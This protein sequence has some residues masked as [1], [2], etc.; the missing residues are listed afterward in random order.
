[1][2]KLNGAGEQ[3]SQVNSHTT[4]IKKSSL[5]VTKSCSSEDFHENGSKHTKYW[6]AL[7]NF[8]PIRMKKRKAPAA[9]D[10]ANLFSFMT[11]NWLTSTIL[12][13]R[14]SLKLEDLPI[15]SEYDSAKS[16]AE[17]LTRLYEKDKK[18]NKTPSIKRILLRYIRT[19]TI[20]SSIAI[21]IS[22][23]A[24][25]ISP[26]FL[27]SRLIRFAALPNPSLGYGIGLVCALGLTEFSRT[28][29][30][31]LYW[32][33]TYR[34]TIRVRA[35]VLALIFQKIA[36]LRSLKDKS[37][38]ELVNLLAND[39][40]R[41][42]EAFQLCGLLVGTPFM[43]LLATIFCCIFIGWTALVGVFAFAAF[44]P[45][46]VFLAEKMAKYR[47]KTIEI[48]DKRV[49]MMNEILTCVKLIKMYAWEKSFAKVI[50]KIRDQERAILA[51]AGFVQSFQVTIVPIVPVMSTVFLFLVHTLVGYPL[52]ATIALTILAIF[53][54]LRFILGVMPHAVKAVSEV[55]V[56][57]NRIDSLLLM[58]EMEK[59]YITTT[60]DV[61]AVEIKHLTSAWDVI[62]KKER[63]KRSKKKV[64]SE[65]ENQKQ[66]EKT[67]PVLFDVSITVPKKRL[68][69]ICGSVG[70]GKSS[71]IS[72][73]LGHLRIQ[74]GSVG[75]NGTLAYVPQQAWIFHASVRDNILFGMPWDKEKYEQVVAACSLS[76]D[77][78]IL[79]DK[80]FTEVGERGLNLSGGQKQRIS[81]AR[82]VYSERE[83]VL[84]DDP[85][86]AVDAHVGKH[87]FF[88][89]IKKILANRTVIFVTHQLQY[90]KDCDEVVMLKEGRITEYG[91]HNELMTNKS[92]YSELINNFYLEQEKEKKSQ[93]E[94]VE[95]ELVKKMMRDKT[96][97]GVSRNALDTLGLASIG[98]RH[99]KPQ[100][101]PTVFRRFPSVRSVSSLTAEG[102]IA[103]AHIPDE[104]NVL[105]EENDEVDQEPSVLIQTETTHTG[106]VSMATYIAYVK[107][108]GGYILATIVGLLFITLLFGNTFNNW[109]LTY[110]INQGGACI[111]QSSVNTSTSAA[112]ASDCE[113]D[114]NITT[115]ENLNFYQIIYFVIL[116]IVIVVGIVRSFLY[117][118]ITVGASSHLHNKLFESVLK[119]PMRF[120]D[121]TPTGRI[122]NRF[123][124][125]MDDADVRI[126]LYMD[127]FLHQGLY[128]LFAI[129]TMIIVF[130]WFAIAIAV[131]AVIFVVLYV[132]FRSAMREFKRLENV[133]R[134]PWFSHV[135]STV[136]GLSTI[137]AYNKT[138]DV[139]ETFNK[140]LD[141]NS[142]PHFTYLCSIRWL[143]V[144][145]DSLT[146]LISITI[147][148]FVVIS[149]VAPE[150]LGQTSASF[151]GLALSYAITMTT[152][153]QV[154]VR[155]SV[156][157][158]SY[159]TSVERINEYIKQ[160]FSEVEP[161][162]AFKNPPEDWPQ[163]GEIKFE[164]VSMRYRP[165]LPLVLKRVSFI[166]KPKE[167]I[168][169]VGRTGSGKSS[170]GTVLFKL[171]NLSSGRILIDNVNIDEIGLDDL[172]RN[173]SIIPQDPVLFVGTVRY[174]LDPFSQY[175][176]EE[177]WKALERTH[178]KNVI[179][180]LSRKLE[181][182]VVENGEN[183][184]VGE[185]QLLCMAR[186]I[187]RHSRI[188]MLDE[189]TAAIDS[190]TDSLVQETIRDVFKDCTMLTIAHRLNTVLTCDK[191][192]VLDEG[193]VVELDEPTTLLRNPK[194]Y[195]SKMILAAANVQGKDEISSDDVMADLSTNPKESRDGSFCF[196]IGIGH[197]D[198]LVIRPLCWKPFR[199]TK[200]LTICQSSLVYKQFL[201]LMDLY[202][203]R[204]H[205]DIIIK[206]FRV[207]Q[208]QI[209]LLQVNFRESQD[210]IVGISVT[211]I[212]ICLL[213]LG[214]DQDNIYEIFPVIQIH[215]NLVNR[216]NQNVIIDIYVTSIQI[217]LLRHTLVNLR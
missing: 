69:G 191:I 209:Y 168:G 147:A 9:I 130:P 176:D 212:Q 105:D 64:K 136:Q 79:P 161:G 68:I 129:V 143:S 65:T 85:L 99:P 46:Q 32:A 27:V 6:R 158:E 122:L 198:E 139:I 73:I 118:R 35:A 15:L 206:I 4:G 74:K 172:R 67:Q 21:S 96:F 210:V 43:L 203:V 215:T 47:R 91:Q 170:L 138:D 49:R 54:S 181:A 131:L 77:F 153:F 115:G 89:C 56:S 167:K 145:L 3:K 179:S 60:S 128:L 125:D 159:F 55:F 20:A 23:T 109:W 17:R 110:W 132:F 114:P 84:L 87:I 101:S 12:K 121:T 151:A 107:A 117:T 42:D 72:S 126:P 134:S 40:Q 184:S 2:T 106:S 86:S 14:K 112:S 88:E 103:I 155:F 11:F 120:F 48:T 16:S 26:A 216:K 111:D 173:L 140:L 146:V 116:V 29:F 90:L 44:L 5:T 124:R 76:S 142:T 189:A 166:I 171:V 160:C 154:C 156:E 58:E 202:L 1:M 152:L 149:A 199:S 45:L 180:E 8:K 80:D 195:F 108:S 177:I 39:G 211:L 36:R 24:A 82:A 83:I 104:I 193:K 165:K 182:E 205:Q 141:D 31:A 57:F 62:E 33:I 123:S 175:S 95:T 185:R 174:N 100:G 81:L 37:V 157:T 30:F 25:V 162:K 50:G 41:L 66:T 169:I 186:A 102:G 178:M 133:T 22:V 192:M 208:I 135:T 61:T 78:E 97:S 71:F 217:C 63:S 183:F 137:H 28:C 127:L 197:L 38:G 196:V 190:E 93:G 188:I 144:R 19:R 53:N 94:T 150:G 18:E 7:Q 200:K 75:I 148:L 51:R 207:T 70:S 194:S 52:D 113:R 213:Y 204:Q 163:N 164:S 59:Y 187:L 13:A 98:S 34:T 214:K 10:N 119:S 201:T 92:D